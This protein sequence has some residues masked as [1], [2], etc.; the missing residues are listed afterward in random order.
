MPKSE[1]EVTH[2]KRD[3]P[4]TILESYGLPYIFWLYFIILLIVLGAMTLPAFPILEKLIISTDI[5]DKVMGWMTIFTL[6][7]LPVFGLLVLF[8]QK[9]IIISKN[10]NKL[11]IKNNILGITFSTRTIQVKSLSVNHY[12]S[13]PNMAKINRETKTRPFE[14]RGHFVLKV[15]TTNEESVVIDRHTNKADL[16]GLRKIIELRSGI[17]A[18]EVSKK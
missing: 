18:V 9:K 17:S 14:N 3:G 1:K 6:I 8:Y 16:E 10:T 15:E 7:G 2:V 5:I 13:S 12:L 4:E 11:I